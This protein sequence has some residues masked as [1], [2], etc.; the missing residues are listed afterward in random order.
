[1]DTNFNLGALKSDWLPR[2]HIQ[3]VMYH[4]ENLYQDRKEND[5]D[6]HLLLYLTNSTPSISSAK[7]IKNTKA[8]V[9]KE[10]IYGTGTETIVFDSKINPFLTITRSEQGY[11]VPMWYNAIQMRNRAIPLF[12]LLAHNGKPVMS[13]TRITNLLFCEQIQLP[14]FEFQLLMDNKLLFLKQE[15]KYLFGNEFAMVYSTEES[16]SVR[17]CLDYTSYKKVISEG[18]QMNISGYLF[19]SVIYALVVIR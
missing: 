8:L 10:W 18:V 16:A 5:S 6:I 12:R 15:K 19:G 7:L 4:S 9:S 13:A 17:I 14:Y 3:V 11:I 1:M 2:W